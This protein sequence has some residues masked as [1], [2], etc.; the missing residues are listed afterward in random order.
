[1]TAVVL[2]SILWRA[3]VCGVVIA[4][5]LGCAAQTEGDEL[6]RGK[7]QV[8][9]EDISLPPG[10]LSQGMAWRCNR[11]SFMN[12]AP[13]ASQ[14][15]YTGTQCARCGQRIKLKAATAKNYVCECP[16]CRARRNIGRPVEGIYTCSQCNKQYRLLSDKTCASLAAAEKEL[17]FNEVAHA[18]LVA[19]G[20]NDHILCI[21]PFDCPKALASDKREQLSEYLGSRLEEALLQELRTA[22]STV[23]LTDRIRVAA[24]LAELRHSKTYGEIETQ[25]QLGR[26]VNADILVHGQVTLTADRILIRCS[27]TEVKSG[28]LLM[29]KSFDM[30]QNRYIRAMVQ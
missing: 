7:D 8:L 26:E 1:M 16:H 14:V 19:L 6:V 18:L 30:V 24:R 23:R 12:I 25:K 10:K 5:A 17:L 20:S 22:R 4:L 15:S 9:S 13:Y 21:L 28:V 2:D 27:M 3:G 29:V 11:C